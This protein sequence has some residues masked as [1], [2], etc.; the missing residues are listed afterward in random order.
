MNDALFA[1][2]VNAAWQATVIGAAGVW[3]ARFVRHRFELLAVTLLAAV[4]A[5][6]LTRETAVVIKAVAAPRAD[7]GVPFASIYFAGLA[8]FAIRMLIAAIRAA[9]IAKTAQ[10]FRG[11]IRISPD[12][13]GPITIGRTVLLPA[14]IASDRKLLAAA[15]A[16]EHAHVRRNDYALHVALE[17]IALPLWFHPLRFVLRRAIAEARELA[18]DE[19]AAERRGRRTY[20]EALVMLANVAAQ[21]MAVGMASSSIEKRV[22][23]LLRARTRAPRRRAFLLI[24]L[25]AAIACTHFNAVE[26]PL[27][28]RWLLIPEASSV[29]YERFTQTIEQEPT[30][31]AFHQERTRSGQTR[32]VNWAVNTDGVSHPIGGAGSTRRVDGAATW[33]EGRLDIR[34]TGPGMHHEN[35]TAFVRDGRLV[36]DGRTETHTYHTEFRRLQP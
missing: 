4:A 23:A 19:Q 32:S 26:H 35:A 21:P 1:F 34:I 17:L 24:P 14:A 29:K 9:R 22:A 3:L 15:V 8:F 10:P 7:T 6:M 2:V 11:R 20:A 31:I 28:G 5:P 27:C 33:R 13:R 36:V 25:L 16:H 18:C 12:V 30:R